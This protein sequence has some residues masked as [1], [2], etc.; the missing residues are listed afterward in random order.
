MSG[1][2]Q[3]LWWLGVLAL[4][5]FATYHLR[6]V[7]LPF[8]AGMAIAYVFDP[9]CDWLENKGMSRT[10][11]TILLTAF[12]GIV[13]LAVVIVI[14]PVVID[15]ITSFIQSLPAMTDRLRLKIDP[16]YQIVELRFSLPSLDSLLAESVNRAGEGIGLVSRALGAVFSRSVA[17]VNIASLLVVTPVVAFYLLRDWDNFINQID[18]LLPRK[19]ADI[20]RGLAHETDEMLA[21]FARGQASVCGILAVIY[22][23]GYF[24]SGVP[25][26]FAIGII[27]GLLSFIPY[28]GSATGLIFALLASLLSDSILHTL[29]FSVIVFAVGQFLEG[30]FLTPKL[31]GGRIRLHPV[32][33]I[34]ALFAFG[35]LFGF[36]GLLIAVPLAAI[37]GV[38]VRFGITQYKASKLYSGH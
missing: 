23:F 33:I 17:L 5:L 13:F 1:T 24:M 31:V 32:W 37:V 8:V 6:S 29:A 10:W 30:N 26:G 38:L 36:V 27:A 2:K 18:N 34:F 19:H 28:V 22:G 7:L 14:G 35:S 12:V 11:A 16:L 15:Q 25:F 3:V 9:V 4:S 21:G 20:I